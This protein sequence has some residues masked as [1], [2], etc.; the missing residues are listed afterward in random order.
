[1]EHIVA[2]AG[3]MSD[4]VVWSNVIG[5]IQLEIPGAY[6]DSRFHNRGP[7]NRLTVTMSISKL[8]FNFD[9][10]SPGAVFIVTVQYFLVSWAETLTGKLIYSDLRNVQLRARL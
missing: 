6:R 7:P 4:I 2:P 5:K 10:Q 1:M 9:V 8:I 3:L